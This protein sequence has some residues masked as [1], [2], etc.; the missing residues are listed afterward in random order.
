MYSF[1]VALGRSFSC[2]PNG[3]TGATAAQRPV[4]TGE[5]HLNEAVVAQRSLSLPL[6]LF[7][8]VTHPPLFILFY[9][10][11]KYILFCFASSL[12]PLLN[13]VLNYGWE[14][15]SVGR[16]RCARMSRIV[17]GRLSSAVGL[18]A[19]AASADVARNFYCIF[20][21]IFT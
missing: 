5:W 17:G 13:G 7:S 15:A 3:N 9:S 19:H 6:F 16:R 10:A 14:R 20:I 8:V 1:L 12:R 21:L 2:A 4:S 11:Y 18:A